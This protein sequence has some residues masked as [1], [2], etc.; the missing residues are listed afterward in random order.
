MRV[1]VRETEI[2]CESDSLSPRLPFL[3]ARNRLNKSGFKLTAAPCVTR[4]GARRTN[5][6]A[7]VTRLRCPDWVQSDS[8]RAEQANDGR[9]QAAGR[10][11]TGRQMRAEAQGD[12]EVDCSSPAADATHVPRR[13]SRMSFDPS[14]SLF[15]SHAIPPLPTAIAMLL[16]HPNCLIVQSIAQAKRLQNLHTMTTRLH[17]NDPRAPVI[18]ALVS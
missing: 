2:S 7:A 6:D 1:G 3:P 5:T 15:P 13:R 14:S 18:H 16:Q 17:H 9:G 12:K 11:H 4:D 8:R 10:R